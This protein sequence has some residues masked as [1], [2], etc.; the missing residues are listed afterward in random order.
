VFYIPFLSGFLN[1]RLVSLRGSK[2]FGPSEPPN[3]TSDQVRVAINHGRFVEA[4]SKT[5]IRPKIATQN[6]RSTS[7]F[8]LC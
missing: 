8:P 1:V 5:W 7:S 6:D 4:Y 2:L 3:P